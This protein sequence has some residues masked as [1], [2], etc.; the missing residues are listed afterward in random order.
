V[1]RNRS[2]H[3]FSWMGQSLDHCESCG[4]SLSCHSLV[5]V[6]PTGAGPFGT[7]WEYVPISEAMR[8]MPMFAALVRGTMPAAIEGSEE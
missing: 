4:E 3:G 2:V 8:R 6:L 7:E 5:E 1:S